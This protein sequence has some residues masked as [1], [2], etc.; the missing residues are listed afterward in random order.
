MNKDILDSDFLDPADKALT[1]IADATLRQAPQALSN[2]L[3]G[4]RFGHPLHPALVAVPLGAWSVSSLLDLYEVATGDETFAAGAD[5]ALGIGLLSSLGAAAT[6]LNDWRHTD[7]PAR[8]AGALHGVLNLVSMALFANSWVQRKRGDRASGI[9]SGMVGLALSMFAGWVG[10]HLVSRERV[11][12]DHAQR[13]PLREFTAVLD[14]QELAEN[15]MKR[16]DLA[17]VEVLL[18]RRNGRVFGIGEKC[19]HLGG[20]LSEGKLEGDAVVC[21]WH[22]SRFSL[23]DGR[24]IDGPTVFA[25]PCFET[26]IKDG[27]IEVRS[28]H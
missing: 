9:G 3:H 22:G 11:G 13:Q 19:A 1:A 5:A 6:G 26:R 8:R 10:G 21:P 14:D 2:L 4:T 16:V 20:P 18:I 17:D 15:Q 12:V 7:R 28:S 27:R 24:V 23:T 25:Q